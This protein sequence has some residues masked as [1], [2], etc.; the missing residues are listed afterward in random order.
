MWD[1][2]VAGMSDKSEKRKKNRNDENILHRKSPHTNFDA[3]VADV[4][5][6]DLRKT[7][8]MLRTF[9]FNSGGKKKKKTKKKERKKKG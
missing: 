5:F 3:A 4:S 6:C 9:D 1:K 2:R 7:S 8:E